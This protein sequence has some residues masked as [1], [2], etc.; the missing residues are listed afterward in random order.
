M[1]QSPL[2]SALYRLLQPLVRIL[3]RNGIPVDVF[4]DIARRVYVDVA[5]KDFA[6]ERRKQSISRIGVLTGLNRKEVAR[7]RNLAPPDEDGGMEHHNRAERVLAAWVREPEF[8]DEKGDPRI[9]P[10]EG[11]ASFATLVKKFSG[12]MPVRA[13]ADE[14]IRVNSL[15]R[16][17]AGELRLRSRGYVPSG[18]EESM[19]I[20]GIHAADLLSTFDGNLSGDPER[21]MWQREVSYSRVPVR[22]VE[23]FK[24]FS[25]RWGQQI[26]EELDRWLAERNVS[27][28]HEDEPTTRLGF[29]LYQIRTDSEKVDP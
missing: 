27:E 26:L 3:L 9:L 1:S 24:R 4:E 20:F 18:D 6:L 25:S 29:G 22:H 5:D 17:A 2:I 13:V 11:E 23:E 21:S 28:D 14:L 8:L 12:D 15:E 10:L 7:L 19:V 16:T